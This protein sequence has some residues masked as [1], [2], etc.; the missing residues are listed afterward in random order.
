MRTMMLSLSAILAAA[1]AGPALAQEDAAL[2][3]QQSDTHGAY[4]ADSG[5]QALYLF[6]T[7]QQ[8]QEGSEAQ[9]TCTDKCAQA[10]PPYT[11]EGE[12][13]VGGQLDQE[14]VGTLE[15]DDGSTQLTYGGWPLYYFVK[16]QAP[17]DTNGQDVH[18]FD[19]EWYLV[20]PDGEKNDTH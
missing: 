14:L 6:T 11:V 15:R 8:G 3:I 13:R 5:G 10:W 2:T 18:G 19:G 4:I 20:S 12:P 1:L 9:T 7:D 17:G 16:D